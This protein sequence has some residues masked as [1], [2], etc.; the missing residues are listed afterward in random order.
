MTNIL[1]A[2]GALGLLFALS[3]CLGSTE[4][5]F[6]ADQA[7]TV[8]GVEGTYVQKDSSSQDFLKVERI[9]GGPDYAYFDPK[10]PDTDRGRMRAVSVGGDMYV[11]QM[12]DDTW[13]AGVYWQVLVKIEREKDVV[14]RV[15]VLF[16]EDDAVAALAAQSGVELGAPGQGDAYGPKTLKGSREAIA[17]FLKKLPTLPLREIGTYARV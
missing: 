15:V 10:H 2:L 17:A 12:R 16:A 5:I 9:G 14:A 3:G 8:P 1:R 4:E 6:T 7:A 11:L 13:P